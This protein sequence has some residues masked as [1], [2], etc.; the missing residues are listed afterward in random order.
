MTDILHRIIIETS[1]EKVFNAITKQD[2]LSA[3]WTMAEMK[4]TVG[5]VACFSFGPNGEH[6][7]EME[8]TELVANERVCWKCVSGPWIDTGAFQFNIQADERGSALQFS[9]LGWPEPNEFYMHCNAK[10]GF[11]L[12]VSLKNLLE[13]GIGQPHPNDPSI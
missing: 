5:S 7:V 9:H 6:K 13:K 12:T 3:W 4:G 11:F 2:Q 10:W 8:I 1:P